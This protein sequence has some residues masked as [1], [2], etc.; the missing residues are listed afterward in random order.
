MASSLSVF[1]KTDFCKNYDLGEVVKYLKE[2]AKSSDEDSKEDWQKKYDALRSMWL[3]GFH[4]I[5]EKEHEQREKEREEIVEAI[6]KGNPVFAGKEKLLMDFFI[7]ESNSLHFHI[8]NLKESKSEKRCWK[9]SYLFY[10]IAE[11]FNSV[12]KNVD[13]YD[14]N[15]KYNLDRLIR[16]LNFE[17]DILSRR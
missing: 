12:M 11:T 15:Y 4:C 17:I 5:N 3:A 14:Y 2:K 8:R 16:M 1:C 13:G 7:N 9:L 10:E 6:F